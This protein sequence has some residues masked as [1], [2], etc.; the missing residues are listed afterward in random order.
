MKVKLVSLEELGIDSQ[1]VTF[2]LSLKEE[3]FVSPNG[4][5]GIPGMPGRGTHQQESGGSDGVGG[6][7]GFITCLI[8]GFEEREA[9]DG[10][11]E[12][13]SHRI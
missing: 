5:K 9:G 10:G 13:T 3:K 2:G 12:S 11:Q 1:E 7:A 8:A 6:R 4:G